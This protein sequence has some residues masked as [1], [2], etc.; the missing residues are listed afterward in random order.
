LD[1]GLWTVLQAVEEEERGPG[2]F[3]S[4][5]YLGCFGNLFFW[6][7]VFIA[8][9]AAGVPVARRFRLWQAKR[10]FIES[11]GARLQN[12][13]NADARFQLATIYAE[14]R[15]WRRAA[16]Y[17][18]E[19]VRVAGE[20]PLYEGQIPY[21]F[22]RLLGETLYRR[23]RYEEALDAFQ[24]ALGAKSE[25]GHGDAIFGLGLTHLRRKE[26]AL[27]LSRLKE[28]V[29]ENGSQLEAYFRWAQVAAALDQPDEVAEA[30]RQFGE[31]ARSLP[32]FAKQR[33]VRWRLGFLLFPLTRHLA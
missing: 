20:N 31:V 14:G 2:L 9:V 29:R 18:A 24:R 10:R 23:G 8:V 1:I 15:S 4:L 28:A 3:R 33:K 16:E 12:P 11:Q 7:L 19:A 32:R 17:A 21:H 13:Q 5:F 22:L 30:R 6:W 25:L 27:A 26:H